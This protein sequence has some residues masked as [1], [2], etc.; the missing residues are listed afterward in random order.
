MECPKGF[1]KVVI[2]FKKKYLNQ[3][4][5]TYDINSALVFTGGTFCLRT[6]IEDAYLASSTNFK[7]PLCF[8]M[9]YTVYLQCNNI[10]DFK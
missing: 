9:M 10:Q 6:R 7:S 3:N 1:T 4:W 8:L 5:E 2:A